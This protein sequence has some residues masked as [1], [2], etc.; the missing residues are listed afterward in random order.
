M[1][2][3]LY[4]SL[5]LLLIEFNYIVTTVSTNC[6]TDLGHCKCYDVTDT[7]KFSQVRCG[8]NKSDTLTNANLKESLDKLNGEFDILY[9]HDTAIDT[10]LGETVKTASFKKIFIENNPKLKDIEVNAFNKSPNLIS[11]IIRNNPIMIGTHIFDIAKNNGEK[12][13]TIEFDQNQIVDIPQNAFHS[14][15]NKTL[16]LVKI[17]RLDNQHKGDGGKGLAKIG[18]SAF[19]NLP[20]LKQLSLDLNIISNIAPKGIDLSSIN[21]VDDHVSVFLSG[22]DLPETEVTELKIIPPTKGS[23]GLV[24]ENNLKPISLEISQK[25][26]ASI[27]QQEKGVVYLTNDK[28][29]PKCECEKIPDLIPALKN[30]KNQGSWKMY[31]K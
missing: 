23:L 10:I 20:N 9:I 18:E 27:I 6:P 16:Q 19:A 12:L 13:D 29:H 30:Q 7:N 14:T 28:Q 15:D 21:K 3:T 24:L 8:D 5:I 25:L 2:R 31:E 1:R 17:I 26:F 4:F 22:N 11:L